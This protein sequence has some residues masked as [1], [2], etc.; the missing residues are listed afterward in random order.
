M[1]DISI[2]ELKMEVEHNTLKMEI[3]TTV[4]ILTAN[5]MA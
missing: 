5:L 2:E 4:T 1:K 3:N